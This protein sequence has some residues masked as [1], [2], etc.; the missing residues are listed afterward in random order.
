VE[1]GL[2]SRLTFFARRLLWP[3]IQ[4]WVKGSAR[5]RLADRLCALPFMGVMCFDVAR[6]SSFAGGAITA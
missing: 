6:K 3:K 5:K 1:K 2:F 4:D